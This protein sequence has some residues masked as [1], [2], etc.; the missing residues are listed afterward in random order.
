MAESAVTL[1]SAS[2]RRNGDAARG[3]AGGRRSQRRML[4]LRV[5]LAALVS[6]TVALTALL[7]HLSW[8]FTAR[9]NVA[10]V[11][12]QLNRQIVDSIHHEVRGV[13]DDAWSMQEAVRSVLFQGTIRTSDE[14]KRE[15]LFLSLLRSQPSLS[16]ISLG[17]PNGNF[18]GAHKV[19]DEEIDMV[20]VKW[21]AAHASARRRIDY[22][23]PDVGDIIFRNRE[24]EDSTYDAT[25]EAWYR[26]ALEEEGPGW[27]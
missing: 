13:L 12:T 14:S 25:K 2:P 18:F 1:P 21:D 9:Q 4:G 6:S 24:I 26:R 8:S 22:Y 11:V 20:E 19:S 7:I 17:F 16:W 10:D 5:A 3:A 15:F 23:A 27:S